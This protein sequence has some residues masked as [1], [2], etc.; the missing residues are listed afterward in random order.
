MAIKTSIA[1]TRIGVPAPEAYSKIGK[2]QGTKERIDYTVE[3]FMSAEAR[4]ARKSPVA[5]SVFSVNP[6]ELVGDFFPA[7]YANLKTKN[8]FENAEDC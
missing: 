4:Q 1:E 5:V 7:L 8:G 6:S 3:T 2:I